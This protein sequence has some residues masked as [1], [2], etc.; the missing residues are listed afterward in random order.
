MRQAFKDAYERELTLL[1]QRAA[2]FAQDYPGL[3]DR[4]GGLLEENLDPSIQGLLEGSAFLA[5]RVQLN[6]DQQFR[7]FS[8]EL[9]EQLCPEM[10]APLPSAMMVQGTL[11]AKP[12]D[13][14]AGRTVPAGSYI[15]AD[16]KDGNRRVQCRYRL[17]SPLT[18]W[19]VRLGAAQYFGSATPLSALGCDSPDLARA[20][21]K[22]TE[23]GLAFTLE[24]TNGSR[25]QA[26]A[27][28]HLDVTF[29]GSLRNAQALHARVLANTVRVSLRWEDAS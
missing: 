6:I 19:P 7:T 8:R 2:A 12:E 29:T 4:L 20:G 22:K 15:E 14:E 21:D 25:M 26:L 3:A 9:L 23:A 5:A 24:T 11:P 1:K 13:I 18:F 27:C 17:A 10:T 28:D 16:F